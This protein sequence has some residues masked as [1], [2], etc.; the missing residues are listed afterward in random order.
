MAGSEMIP[1][2]ATG[3]AMGGAGSCLGCVF[4]LTEEA[5]GRAVAEDQ[6]QIKEDGTPSPLLS[7]MG[8]VGGSF[9]P[10]EGSLCARLWE[11][12]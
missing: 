2:E 6:S 7:I 5:A 12:A 8:R 10:R 11:E 4:E 3:V 1:Q 9:V